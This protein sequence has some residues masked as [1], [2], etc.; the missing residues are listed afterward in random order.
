[1]TPC[2]LSGTNFLCVTPVFCHI[3]LQTCRFVTSPLTH[4][5]AFCWDCFNSH[6]SKY[7][8]WMTWRTHLCIMH[9]LR[10]PSLLQFYHFYYAKT[11][12]VQQYKRTV[13][14]RCLWCCWTLEMSYLN[15]TCLQIRL[16]SNVKC[17]TIQ[18]QQKQYLP[19]SRVF[20]VKNSL[21]KKWLL[22]HS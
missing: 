14:G 7:H 20:K 6:F 15:T 10:F 11:K 21:N 4:R 16:L 12:A 22:L 1:M 8:V 9:R 19:E 3:I 17:S 5:T 18:L 13:V 2:D